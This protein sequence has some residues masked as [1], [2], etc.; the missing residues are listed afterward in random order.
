MKKRRITVVD[1]NT[2]QFCDCGEYAGFK[3]FIGDI[4]IPM[5]FE[6]LAELGIKIIKGLK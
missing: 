6:C 2:N 4:E 5:C 3:V 1:I